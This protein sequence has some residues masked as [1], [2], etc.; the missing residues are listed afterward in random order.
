M[1]SLKN[2]DYIS[3][4]FQLYQANQDE[5]VHD[6]KLDQCFKTKERKVTQ[7]SHLCSNNP[8]PNKNYFQLNHMDPST[9]TIFSCKISFG[10]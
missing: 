6:L 1:K 3:E 5:M 2:T 9:E 7:P 8:N 10:T 4:V